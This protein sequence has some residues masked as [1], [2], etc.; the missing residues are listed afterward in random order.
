MYRSGVFNDQ[1][2]LREV[3]PV[4]QFSPQVP[5]TDWDI[6]GGVS[7]LPRAQAEL[8]ELPPMPG[9]TWLT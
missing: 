2:W 7:L 5:R 4:T 9:S 3:L 8:S 6:S 1:Q